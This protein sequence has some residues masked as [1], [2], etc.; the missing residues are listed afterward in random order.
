MRKVCTLVMVMMVCMMGKPT[1]VSSKA[2]KKGSLDSQNMFLGIVRFKEN[3]QIASQSSG[4][5]EKVLFELGAKVKKGDDLVVLSSDLLQK[6]IQSKEAKLKQ[7][8]ILK[9]YQL[10]E[11]ERYKNLLETDSIALQQYEK[12]NYEFQVQDLTILS[13]EAELDQARVELSQKTIKAPFDGIIVKKNVN[14]GEWIKVGD[15]VCEILNN[16]SPEAIVDVPSSILAFNKLGDSISVNINKKNYTG[17][18]KAIIPKAD[19]RSRT[20]PVI[21]TLPNDAKLFDGMAASAM[22]KSGGESQGYI[23]PRD[24]VIE[25]RNRPSIF[26]IR[27]GK[28]VAVGVEVLAISGNIAVVRGNLRDKERVIY[29]GQYRLQEGTEVK[30]GLSQREQKVNL[31]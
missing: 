14:I 16:S 20:F 3:S 22:L 28:A 2:I 1:I 7:A 31:V 25:Y 29:R 6:D 12:L 30:E 27:Q 11:L 13:L 24:S 19:S 17:K 4:V 23:I 8:K 9:D 15:G 21:I 18:I 5:V 10:K 26:V